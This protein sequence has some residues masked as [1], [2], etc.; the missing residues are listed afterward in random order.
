MLV[1][2]ANLSPVPRPGYRLGLPRATRWREVLNTDSAYLRR[3]RRRQPRRRG[4]RADPVARP[5]GLGRAD[6]AAARGGLARARMSEPLPWERPLGARVVDDEHAEFRVWAPRASTIR[7]LGGRAGSR[8]CSEVGH[9]VHEAVAPGPR[10]R[11][12]L[13]RDRRPAAAG[14]VLALAAGGAA[15]ALARARRRRRAGAVRRAPP[16]SRSSS[17]TS[18]TSARSARRARS[19]A[20]SRTCASSPSSAS[21]RS[22]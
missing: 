13:V 1:F 19:T 8:R 9:G 10:G 11:R 7:R 12:L 21:P 15:R 16:R 17:S 6:A 20:R 18:C 4:A 5:A 2:V 14:P 22:S 3:Q